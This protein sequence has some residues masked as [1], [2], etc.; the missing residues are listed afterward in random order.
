MPTPQIKEVSTDIIDDAG[1]VLKHLGFLFFNEL[2]WGI[3]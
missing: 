1:I 3:V 2:A